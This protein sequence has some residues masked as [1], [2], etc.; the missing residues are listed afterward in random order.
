MDSPRFVRLAHGDN[1][2]VA[3]DQ[4]AAGNSAGGATARARIPRGHK[5]AILPIAMDEPVR[6]Y[7]Q[8]IG[9]ASKEIVPGDWVHE[10]NVVMHDFAR[11]Y[12]FAEDAKNDE[13]LPP[14][15][16]AT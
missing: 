9:F 14:E 7:G 16:R 8:I 6:K 13:M 11:D 3:V 5:M 2:I 4:I 15:M 12:R 1:V 10:H